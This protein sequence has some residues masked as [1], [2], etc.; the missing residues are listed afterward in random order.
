MLPSPSRLRPDAVAPSVRPDLRLVPTKNRVAVLLNK[1]AKRVSERTYHQFERLMPAE[2]LFFSR[3]LDEAKIHAQTI[4]D[5]RYGTV[6]VGGGD[7]T[8]TCTMN[9]LMN[10]AEAASTTGL[11][12]ALPDVG[13]LRLGTGNG[14]AYLTGAGKP[15]NDVLRA[16]AGERAPAHPL[17]LI[18]D[19]KSGWVFPFA[20]LGYDA[21]VLNDYINVV[22]KTKTGFGRALAKSLPGYFYAIGTRTIPAE[23]RQ[24]RPNLRLTALGRASIIDPETRE[25]IPLEKNATLFDGIARAVSVGTSPF[26]GFGMK[27]LPYARRRS[28]RFQ[29]RVSSASISYLLSHLPSLWAGTLNKHMVDFLVEGVRIESTEKLPLQ[30]AGDARG[31]TNDVELRLAQRAFRFVE[32]TGQAR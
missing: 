32:G 20:S 10:A 7:G 25:E 26:Y 8:V 31:E 14:L 23:L 9:L 11:K 13:V 12:H 30:F 19:G 3:D 18:E 4:V 1:N 15:Q 22:D 21:R 2:D 17:R 5:R 16:I 27:I 28:D 29:V 6:L 24:K